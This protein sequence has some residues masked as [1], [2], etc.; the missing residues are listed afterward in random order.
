MPSDP[1]PIPIDPVPGQPTPSGP[2]RR[3]ARARLRAVGVME[4]STPART[5][6]RYALLV[7]VAAI[8]IAPLYAIVMQALKTGPEAIDHP[9]SLRP[10][11]LT[12]GTVRAAWRQGDLGRLM[13]NS[14]VM[15]VLVTLGVLITSLMAAYAFAFLDFPGRRAG[16]AVF[17]ATMLVP[18]EVTTL[19]NKRTVDA[20]GWKNTMAGLVVPLLATGLG[21]FLIRQVFLQIPRELREAGSLD[22]LGH[23]RFLWEVAM[24][25]SRPSLGALGLLTFLT[26]WNQYLWP[27]SV[28]D[29]LEHR[30]IQIGLE[31]LNGGNVDRLNLVTAGTVI[32]ALPILVM[33]VV[34]QRH[35]VRG[36]TAG[37]VKG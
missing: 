4:R 34:F 37:A 26:T 28:V 7:F 21:T 15:S 25:L 2:D 14:T 6:G 22:G 11:P 33:L 23:G 35:L 12:L 30:T 1:L 8:V 20:L 16:F 5:V 10:W 24:P 13:V 19:I 31:S 32:A 17:L 9:R 36:L 3:R 29:D 18:I 27:Q